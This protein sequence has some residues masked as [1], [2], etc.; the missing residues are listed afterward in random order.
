MYPDDHI[1][2]LADAYLHEALS[3]E[4]ARAVERHVKT[5]RICQT[6][7]EE[8]R[9]RFE[10]MHSLPPVEASEQLVQQTIARV[11]NY[12]PPLRFKMK[13][14]SFAAALV[15]T[16]MKCPSS[17]AQSQPTRWLMKCASTRARMAASA[18]TLPDQAA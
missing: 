17:M 6:A 3:P 5:C 14:W 1:L 15:A 8:A 7:M 2:E 12:R 16:A 9:R 4:E 18:A 11:E 10:A 13:R